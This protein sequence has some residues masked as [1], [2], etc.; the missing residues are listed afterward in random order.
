MAAPALLAAVVSIRE[1]AT[2][3][4]IVRQAEHAFKAAERGSKLT[5]QFLAFRARKNSPRRRL[6]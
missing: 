3:P 6:I 2:N 5:A 4:R 1:R